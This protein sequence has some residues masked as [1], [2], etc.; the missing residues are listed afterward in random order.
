MAACVPSND[1]TGTEVHTRSVN[2]HA[3]GP[4][5]LIMARC[6]LCDGFVHCCD[7]GMSYHG[8]TAHVDCVI[9]QHDVSEL[10]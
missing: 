4:D 9:N 3:P 7:D 10:D 6:V 2:D 8:K 1:S 5:C